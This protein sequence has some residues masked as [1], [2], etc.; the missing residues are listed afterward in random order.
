M[1]LI[2]VIASILI[3]IAGVILS[4]P[5]VQGKLSKGQNRRKQARAHARNIAGK[6]NK[7]GN[8]I[9][10]LY[11]R[12]AGGLRKFEGPWTINRME[13]GNV[14]LHKVSDAGNLMLQL[15][16][17]EYESAITVFDHESSA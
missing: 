1:F 14:L 6:Y 7:E 12:T 11:L 16:S 5:S 3:P 13:P 8:V 4:L 10:M 15:S 2:T 17:V 9:V